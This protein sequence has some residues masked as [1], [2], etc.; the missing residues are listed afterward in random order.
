MTNI[1]NLSSYNKIKNALDVPLDVVRNYSHYLA[2]TYLINEVLKY[3][4]KVKEQLRN[5]KKIYTT[6][7]GL[8][9]AVS[10][11]FSEDIGR[12][13]ENIVFA[14]LLKQGKDIYY[15]KNKH[16][17]DFLT[18]QGITVDTILQV[19]MTATDNKKA[20]QREID[21]MDEGLE[22]FKTS[23]GIIITEDWEEDIRLR[24]GKIKTIPLWKWLL[25]QE[26]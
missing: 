4:F 21:A 18:Q 24:N 2:E 17:I 7:I 5:P 9:N 13:A 12:I 8:R 15:Y 16:E 10:Y 20:M 25:K 1:S 23:K 3:S 11:R 19:C 6:D 22:I 14:A 26:A